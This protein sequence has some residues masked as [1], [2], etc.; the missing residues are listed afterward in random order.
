MGS[1]QPRGHEGHYALGFCPVHS[2]PEEAQGFFMSSVRKRRARRTDGH[3]VCRL[4]FPT[5]PSPLSAVMP[6]ANLAPKHNDVAVMPGA[7]AAGVAPASSPAR[8]GGLRCPTRSCCASPHRACR[9]HSHPPPEAPSYSAVSHCRHS[10][11]LC[12]ATVTALGIP[13]SFSFAPA[14]GRPHCVRTPSSRAHI[15]S[16]PGRRRRPLRG[17][18]FAPAA[19]WCSGTQQ[20][21]AAPR[22]PRPSSFI[23]S[24]PPAGLGSLGRP[25]AGHSERYC[26][27]APCHLLKSE[28]GGCGHFSGP[29]SGRHM[30]DAPPQR[31]P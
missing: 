14:S 30:R 2:R 25:E 21:R 3:A 1:R 13:V 8:P 10:R 9:A 16:P 15:L 27:T 5:R 17:D 12:F 6:P 19:S 31:S 7:A 29:S 11:S 23:L 28:T 20:S 22:L 26:P 4:S 24:P 18:C